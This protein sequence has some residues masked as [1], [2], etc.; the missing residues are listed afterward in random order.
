ME[1]N[2]GKEFLKY[3]RYEHLN[4]SDQSKG[5]E[6]PPIEYLIKNNGKTIELTPVEE[7]EGVFVNL[8]ELIEQRS[9]ERRYANV[10]MSLKELSYL[11]WSTQGIK[12]IISRETDAGMYHSTIRT[13]PSAGARHAFETVLLINNV[14]GIKQ[15][16][17]QYQATKHQLIELSLEEGIANH[18]TAACLRQAF[19]EKSAA[20]FIWVADVRR[21]SWRYEL[22]GY[23]YLFLDCGHVCQNLYLTAESIG[24]G[25]CAIAA[26]DDVK[27][28]EV[29]KLNGEE[30]FVVYLATVGK[31]T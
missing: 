24:F 6:Q 19:I 26:Y 7:L 22:R 14:E 30:Q 21:M 17:Y 5:L 9:S 4:E 12:R 25:V 8:K 1:N 27:L 2:I 16:L 31:K 3:T 28:N 29:L 15:G 13:V 11:L 10:S 18:I 20:T 23:R